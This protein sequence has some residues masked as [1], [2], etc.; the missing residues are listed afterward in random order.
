L[1]NQVYVANYSS[2]SVSAINVD[3][4]GGQQ[5]VPITVSTAAPSTGTDPLTVAL[6]NTSLGTPYMTMNSAPTLTTTVT[7]AYTSSS[8]YVDDGSAVNPPPTALYYQVD[9]GSGLWSMATLSSSTGSNPA[10]FS[11]PLTGQTIGLHTLYLYAAYGDEGVPDSSAGGTGNSPEISNVTGFVYAIVPAPTT[12]TLVVNKNPV[13]AGNSVTFTATVSTP[14]GTAAPTGT[15]S[16]YDAISGTPE[17]MGTGTLSLVNDSDVAELQT[18]FTAGGSHPITS[19][20][21]GDPAHTG[22]S[23]SL[24][25]TVNALVLPVLTT[26]TPNTTTPLTS[27]SVTFSW[28]PGNQATHFEFW[29]GTSLGSSNLYDSGNVTVTTKT[30][31]D[32]PSNGEKVYVRLY[33]LINGAWQYT[34]YTY[35]A[36]GSPTQAQLTTPA[37]N[38]TT[39]LTSTSVTFSWNPGNLATHFELWV[40]TSLGSSNLYN[41]GSVTATTETVSDLPSNGEKVYVRLYSLLNGAWQYTSYTYVASG[42][43]TQAELTTPTPNTTTP[44]TGT[45]VTFSWNPGNLA[46]HFE[47]WVGTSLGS[48]NLY[49]SGNVTVTS[50]TV[51]DLPSNG[52]TVYVRLYTLLNGAW[53]STSYTYTAF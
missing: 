7:G 20:Y 49:N 44:L 17:L 25:E 15:V 43:P 32:L 45:S 9:G 48:S 12:T 35:V 19:V 10:T 24:T 11:L 39:P 5:T 46:T 41:S 36:T 50:E 6:P 29:V 52:E 16:F 38:T 3:G 21:G 23:G 33:Y 22:S 40:G 37:P 42:S 4:T 34:S 14:A 31:S 13:V 30:V 8:T 27:T 2:A 1:T 51:S 53:Q 28:N 18:V 26:P 47:V